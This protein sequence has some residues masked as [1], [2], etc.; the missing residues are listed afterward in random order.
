MKPNRSSKHYV[1]ILR[2]KP[3]EID[4]LSHLIDI[5]RNRITPFFELCPPMFNKKSGEVLPIEVITEKLWEL[6]EVMGDLPFYM[7]L[8][9]IR[10]GKSPH[11]DKAIWPLIAQQGKLLSLSLIPVTGFYGKGV[12][13]QRLIGK[14]A[15]DFGNGACIRLF[16]NDVVHS[17]LANR[18]GQ[19]L[20]M[21]SL[22]PGEVDLLIDFQIV[23]AAGPRYS[24]MIEEL[25]FLSEWRSLTLTGGSFPP[26]LGYPMLAH[27]TYPVPRLEWRKYKAEILNGHVTNGLVPR[28]SDFTIQ[29]P[30]Y[31]EPV[32]FPNVSRSIRY[33]YDEYWLVFRGEAPGDG[34][35]G[36]IQYQAQAELLIAKNEYCGADFCFGDGFIM[37]KST[38]EKH[39]GGP[40]QW[41]MA[42][43]NHHITFTV[44]QMNPELWT[45]KQI[46]M[47]PA[48]QA[49]IQ[50]LS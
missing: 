32:A 5:V 10:D 40:P 21:V 15:K 14:V 17:S 22:S 44:Y 46:E 28:F 49:A 26:D 12:D 6:K 13:Y 23:N 1:P 37:K 42:G 2:W 41:L 25:P 39:P 3:A 45:A 50:R 35:L 7:D 43:I 36:N 48:A 8:L 16:H 18:L 19:L 34:R 11:S 31:A 24:D 4:A 29:H 20:S 9:H 38:D 33:T 30:V 47:I 27:N